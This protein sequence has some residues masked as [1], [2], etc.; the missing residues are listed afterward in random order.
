MLNMERH[1]NTKS[2]NLSYDLFVRFN[3]LG[4][5]NRILN[6]LQIPK[7]AFQDPETN[8]LNPKKFINVCKKFQIP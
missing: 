7:A 2:N 5:R 1:K 6:F 3:F 8:L 4:T